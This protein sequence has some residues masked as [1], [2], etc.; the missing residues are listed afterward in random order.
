[1]PIEMF[2]LAGADP[3]VRFSPFCW[4]I[5]MA[6]AHKG[7]D[8]RTVPWRFVE[9]QAISESGQGAVPVILDKGRV[10]HDSWA[11]ALYLE[12]AYP[13]RP[14]LF[15]GTQ[16][17]GLSNILRFWTQTA[18][19]PVILKTIINDLFAAIAPGDKAYFR[20]SREA[21]FGMPLE[22]FA[23]SPESGAAVLEK[24]LGPFRAAL[25]SQ[26]FA[27]GSKPA[28]GDYIVFGAFMWARAVSPI[29]LLDRQDPVYEWR[30]RMLDL[31]AGLGRNAKLAHGLTV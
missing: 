19:H 15:S 24:A 9:K 16:A 10:L 14:K 22:K 28:F 25:D 30:E 6:M 17:R 23:F 12:E 7:L 27:C 11:I 4:R 18:L 29:E 31:H 20:S 1:M 8:V 2:D 26:D 3:E 5:R 21:R 13:D